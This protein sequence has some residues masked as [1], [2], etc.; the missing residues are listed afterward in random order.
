MFD[1]LKLPKGKLRLFQNAGNQLFRQVILIVLTLSGSP[2]YAGDLSASLREN[3]L[4]F[5]TYNHAGSEKATCVGILLSPDWIMTAAHC[6]EPDS[7]SI[8]TRC[9]GQHESS[10][11]LS[12]VQI[13]EIHRHAQHDIALLRT[14]QSGFCQSFEFSVDNPNG[15]FSLVAENSVTESLF[16][17]TLADGA[18]S[19]L[20]ILDANAQNYIVD[21]TKCLTQGDSGTPVFTLDG[22]G[23]VRL[24]AVLISGTSDCPAL[25]ILAN[26]SDMSGWVGP[27]LAGDR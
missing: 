19:A 21:D 10:Q 17:V 6:I 27:I 4:T 18:R 9:Y 3:I 15:V 11:R 20:S 24:A 25:Q 1:F 22:S 5:T 16:T 2:A 23:R 14:E 7:E 13:R 26:V 8:S 12:H